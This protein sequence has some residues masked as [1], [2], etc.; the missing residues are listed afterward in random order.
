MALTLSTIGASTTGTVSS[1]GLGSGIDIN[2]LVTNLVAATITPQQNLITQQQSQDTATISALGA[3]QSVL[4]GLQASVNAL[5]TGGALGD[6]TATS[7][8]TAN[9]TAVASSSAVQGNYTVKVDTLA[10]ANTISSAAY[11]SSSAVVGNGNVTI[12]AGGSSFSVSLSGSEDTLQDLANAINSS[13]DNSGVS[14]SIITSTDGAHLVLNATKTGVSNA[15]SVSSSLLQPF[16]TV[17]DASD[18]KVFVDGF[19]YDS[20]SN[21]ITGALSGVTL[22]LLAADQANTYNLTVSPDTASASSAIAAFVQSYNTAIG[23]LLNDTSYDSV[24]GQ[25]GSLLG[26]SGVTSA[27]QRLQGIESSSVSS[28]GANAIT[29]LSQLGITVNSDGSL[30]LDSTTLNAA[31]S[32]NLNSVQNLL[33][34]P[35]GIMTQLSTVIE[36]VAGPSGVLN[37]QAQS[38][39]T[40]Y[41]NLSHQ[42]TDLQA[43]SQQLTQRYLSQFNAMNAYVAQYNQLSNM[44]TQTFASWNN[45]TTSKNS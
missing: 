16:S 28:N 6:L 22:N 33:S 21:T 25:G 14:A 38:Y 44:L 37:S 45:V 3:A 12:T 26:N 24:T 7:S 35:N 29:T 15:V 13:P 42:L 23:T 30:S 34:G 8:S 5:T 11:S 27:L 2:T 41:Q 31:L 36:N 18:S 10:Q 9:F 43:E 20:S 1:P 4:F 32:Q 39:Q 40:D 19:E 17:Q